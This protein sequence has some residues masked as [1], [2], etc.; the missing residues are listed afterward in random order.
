MRIAI[1]G[2]GGAGKSTIAKALAKDLNLF[3]LDT[4]AMYRTCALKAK[5][6]GIDHKDPAAVSQMMDAIQIDVVLTEE[7]AKLSLDG[8]PVGEEIRTPEISLMA[9]DISALPACRKKLTQLQRELGERYDVVMDGRDIGTVVLPDAEFKVF[10]TASVEERARRRQLELEAKGQNICYTD[11]LS[12]LNYRDQQ[13]S[14]RSLAPLKKADD[15]YE[16]N[17][18]GKTIAEVIA[19]V[20]ALVAGE[21]KPQMEG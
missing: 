1:D 3:Y 14:S 6:L 17:S 5:Q 7:A 18:D 21:L 9:S 13:D 11:I 4:G 2:P 20:K 12:D 15:A 10:L 16:L 8:K 19:E